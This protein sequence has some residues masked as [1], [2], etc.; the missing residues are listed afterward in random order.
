MV[1]SDYAGRINCSGWCLPGTE[2]QTPKCQ[3]C[4][5]KASPSSRRGRAQPH[6][7]RQRWGNEKKPRRPPTGTG[8]PRWRWRERAGRTCFP[9][10]LC[11]QIAQLPETRAGREGGRARDARCAC[12]Y[13]LNMHIRRREETRR[14]CQPPTPWGA[15]EGGEGGRGE[16]RWRESPREAPP[17]PQHPWPHP[18]PPPKPP[19][20][21]A[22]MVP[23]SQRQQPKTTPSEHLLCAMNFPT[24]R[25]NFW[26]H[27]PQAGVTCS[28]KN[29]SRTQA[30]RV[31][32]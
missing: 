31:T 27:L 18:W 16:G 9:G 32:N 22:L 26:L 19:P 10:L 3:A 20:C 30:I 7:C 15:L 24:S 8:H 4:D 1:L 13:V 5:L 21:R 14:N 23:A 28:G 17:S 25:V 6:G 29:S 12:R 11:T 2:T